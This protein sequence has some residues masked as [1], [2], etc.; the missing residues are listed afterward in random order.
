[1]QARI[2]LNFKHNLLM[3]EL[4]RGKT[5]EKLYV[6][7]LNAKKEKNVIALIEVKETNLM[8]LLNSLIAIYNFIK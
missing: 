5:G 7:A 1:M 4:L 8:K 6:Q 2:R 3:F